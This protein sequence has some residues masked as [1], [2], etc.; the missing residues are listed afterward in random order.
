MTQIPKG[1]EITGSIIKEM[2]RR[3]LSS[4][5]FIGQKPIKLTIDRVEKH[6]LLKYD[7]GNSEKNALLIHFQETPK[8]L[9]LNATNIK[10]IVY[11]L[12]T[13]KVKE[14]QGKAIELE[15]QTIKAFGSMKPAVRVK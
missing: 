11:R 7:N 9:K 3:F 15:V 8:P 4:L 10:L 13:N 1:K 5:D 6:A 12:G 2:D 14:W